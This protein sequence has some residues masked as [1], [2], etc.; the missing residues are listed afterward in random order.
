MKH[1]SFQLTLLVVV[2]LNGNLVYGQD[3]LGAIPKKPR[4]PA[5]YKPSTLKEIAEA[6]AKRDELVPFRVRVVY[7]AS[8]RSIS[9]TNHNVLNRWA[10]CCAGNPDHYTRAYLQEMQ[11]TENSQSYWLVVQER[12]L[13]DLH[14]ELK[15]GE[16]VNLFLIRVSALKNGGKRGSVLLLERFEKAGTSKDQIRESVN[17]IISNLPSYA[18]KDLKVEVTEPCRLRITDSS[19]SSSLSKAVASVPLSDLDPMKVSVL[20]RPSGA[21]W[22]LWL[23]TT[24]GKSSILFMLYQGGPAEGGRASKYSVALRDREKAEA[25][26]DAFRDAIRVC[27]GAAGATVN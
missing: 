21:A 12:L 13:G 27:A 10:Q 22:D 26:A 11:F 1:K 25:I 19:K 16:I 3:S 5:D 23:H 17:W 4:T 9:K 6:P 15:V 14:A 8:V 20:G 2:M 18:E 7:T 24:S